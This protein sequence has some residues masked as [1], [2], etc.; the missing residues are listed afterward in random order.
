MET[1]QQILQMMERLLTHQEEAHL[2]RMMAGEGRHLER[3]VA[4][5]GRLKSCANRRTEPSMARCEINQEIAGACP[6][7]SKAGLEEMEA[8]V[9]TLRRF[10]TTWRLPRKKRRPQ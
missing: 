1:E 3:L 8:T 9:D 5:L 2:E 4:L 7:N 10:R 6:E